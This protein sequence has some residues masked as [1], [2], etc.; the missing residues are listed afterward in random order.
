MRKINLGKNI[1]LIIMGIALSGCV[2]NSNTTVENNETNTPIETTEQ[3]TPAVTETQ[4]DN[5]DKTAILKDVMMA[6]MESDAEQYNGFYCVDV[7]MDNENEIVL[8][9]NYTNGIGYDYLDCVGEEV[10]IVQLGGVIGKDMVL[11]QKGNFQNIEYYNDKIVSVSIVEGNTENKL[12]QNY[13]VFYYNGEIISEEEG[14][15]LVNSSV[16][17]PAVLYEI[18]E[19]N[20]ANHIDINVGAIEDCG[21]KLISDE[22]VVEINKGLSL[23]QKA[24]LGQVEVYDTE[25]GKMKNVTELPNYYPSIEFHYCDLDGDGVKEV[26]LRFAELSILHEID[27]VV[28]RYEE[29]YRA[30]LPLYEDGTMNSTAGAAYSELNKIKEF[31]KLGKNEEII[32]YNIDGI[33]YKE[34][35]YNGKCIELTDEEYAEIK[36]KYKEIP[37]KNYE[38]SVS[39]VINVIK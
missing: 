34:Y 22:D 36:A 33:M 13:N 27:G 4:A 19:T 38:Y 16:A 11:N 12:F 20:I 7:D 26:V 18:T 31:T 35:N 2:A 21:F 37:A 32:F 39:N 10:H 6:N 28:Y 3:T 23:M 25:D 24:V 9:Y 1:F 29:S 15:Q 17:Q 5:I 8:I 14:E 30:M